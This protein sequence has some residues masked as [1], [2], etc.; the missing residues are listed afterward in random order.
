MS[1]GSWSSVRRAVP[2]LPWSCTRHEQPLVVEARGD[3]RAGAGVD[4]GVG[5]Q[6]GQA[7]RRGLRHVL[8][9]VPGREPAGQRPPGE[10]RRAAVGGELRGWR[11]AGACRRCSSRRACVDVVV[12]VVRG[13]SARPAA[14]HSSRGWR[15]RCSTPPS[16]CAQLLDAVVELEAA[17]LDEPVAEEQQQACRAAAPTSVACQRPGAE[18]ERRPGRRGRAS[19]AAPRRAGEQRRR[20]AGQRRGSRRCRSA[21]ITPYATVTICSGTP[22]EV[23]RASSRSSITAGVGSISA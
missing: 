9:D 19:R 15:R 11:S 13:A 16:R 22:S 20:V 23:T 8:V 14:A 7:Q 4:D 2:R 17:G 6:L 10:R 5:H 18:P 21:S 12:A 3:P 1:L